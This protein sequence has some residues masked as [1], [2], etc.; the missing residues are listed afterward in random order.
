MEV[1]GVELVVEGSSAEY[2]DEV[3]CE[4]TSDYELWVEVENSRIE[5]W[6]NSDVTD[7]FLEFDPFVE[8]EVHKESDMSD[9]KD[10]GESRAEGCFFSEEFPVHTPFEE[11]LPV[12]FKCF[13]NIALPIVNKEWIANNDLR[14]D[15]SENV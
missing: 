3:A 10:F 9:E 6:P 2:S 12:E 7:E 8:E 5:K 14:Y 15:D 11:K 1:P 13:S 4:H